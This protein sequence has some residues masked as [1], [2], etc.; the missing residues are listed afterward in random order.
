MAKYFHDMA[1][2]FEAAFKHVRSGG[3]VSYIIGNSTFYGHLI[4]AQEWYAALLRDTGFTGV[5]VATLRKR[6]SNLALFEYEVSA[7][8]P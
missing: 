8:R 1:R 4:P 6:N 5:R 3:E 2:H 7:T